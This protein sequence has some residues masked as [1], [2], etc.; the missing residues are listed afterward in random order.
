[1]EGLVDRSSILL[2]STKNQKG[3]DWL[4]DIDSFW[5]IS[6]FIG[7]IKKSTLMIFN[8][9]ANLKYKYGNRHFGAIGYYIDTVGKNEKIIKEY[10]YKINY[11]WL[12]F[13]KFFILLFMFY[14]NLFQ[15]SIFGNIISFG[16]QVFC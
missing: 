3:I 15:C 5:N 11:R 6:Q 1:M 2:I 12:W 7:Y 9:Y 8:R 13:I 16:S 14:R 10:I 4:S